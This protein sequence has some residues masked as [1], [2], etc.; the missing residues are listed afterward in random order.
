MSP[1]K[2]RTNNDIIEQKLEE[3]LKLFG[4]EEQRRQAKHT[5]PTAKQSKE[6]I[7]LGEAF[8]KKLGIK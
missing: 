5:S 1:P 2:K 8:E 6:A 3:V 4:G 7:E